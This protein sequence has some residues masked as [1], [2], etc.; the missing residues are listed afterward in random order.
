MTDPRTAPTRALAALALALVV[1]FASFAHA[2]VNAGLRAID[3]GDFEAA[4]AA[5]ESVIASDA[6]N[7]RAHL[8]LAR[9]AVYAAGELPADA[10]A[11]REAL[12]Q[13]AADAAERATRLA[14]DDPDAHFEV[15]R[16]LGRLAQYRGVL[17][18]LNLAS[19][20]S[21]ALDRTL[22]LD[23][24]HA[25]AWHARGLFHHDVPWI[26][27]GRGGL[28]IP[29]FTRAIEIEPS[30]IS[31]RLAFA[32]VLVD[33]GDAAAAR[34]QLEVAVTLRART[35]LDRQDLEAVRALLAEL[36]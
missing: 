5:F 32:Q 29:S 2:N 3:A 6:D 20:V 30:V 11:E 17:Q 10:D 24:D 34:A 14:P 15:A 4:I 12:F 23:P 21:N 25:A 27:G 7:A 16:A 36:Q 26:A 1:G 19:R 31:H 22:E 28:V 18:S 33:R 9:A 13:R 8:L 35:Y